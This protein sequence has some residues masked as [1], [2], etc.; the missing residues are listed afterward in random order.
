MKAVIYL[1]TSTEEQEPENQKKECLDLAERRG[2][3]VKEV[4]LE[5]ISGY[6]QID[7]P[8]YNKVKELAR[9]G[10]IQAVIVWSLDRWV[11]NRDTL[12]EDTTLL[13]NYGC[14]IHSVKESWL[15]AINIEGSL[16]RT[17]KEFLLGLMGSLGE[18]E[19]QRKSERVKLAV[20]KKD[21]KTVSYKG[22][23]WGRKGLSK[24]KLTKIREYYKLNPTATLREVA[25]ETGVS[26][27]AVHK[28]LPI[29]IG[30]KS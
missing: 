1:R 26:R 21:G 6:K 20:R 24:Q 3:E 12:L 23:K 27:S 18:M 22:K 19:S 5:R 16:G 7:R 2:Y 25:S 28:Y 29:I 9:K 10:E 15:E 11:R 17:I 13:G 4:F 14:K 8:Y 30:G